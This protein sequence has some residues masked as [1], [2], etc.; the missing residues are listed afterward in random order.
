MENDSQIHINKISVT[1][2]SKKK[3]L[4]LQLDESRII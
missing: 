1:R 2:D 4:I 3:N